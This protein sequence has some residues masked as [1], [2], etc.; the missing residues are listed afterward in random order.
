MNGSFRESETSVNCRPQWTSP[1]REMDCRAL[2]QW[3]L[4]FHTILCAFLF[5]FCLG[6]VSTT[7]HPEDLLR[8]FCLLQLALL[9]WMLLSWRVSAGSLFDP[10]TLF[11]FAAA[12]FHIG[13]VVLECFHLNQ[14]AMLNNEFP[15]EILLRTVALVL[16]S[17]ALL[18]LGALLGRL[19][20]PR[21]T[22]VRVDSPLDCAIVR[23]IGWGL[24]A[25]SVVPAA[26][27]L[28]E[29][30]VNTL[31][32]GYFFALFSRQ[33]GTGFA[34]IESFLAA[35]LVP[36][37]FFLLADGVRN[38][39]SRILSLLI[40]VL[41]G[42]VFLVIGG[43]TVAAVSGATYAWMWDRLIGRLP[44]VLILSTILIGLFVI[45]PLVAVIRDS[46]GD[47]L[48]LDFLSQTWS[49]LDHPASA[50]LKETGGS[51]STVAYTVELVPSARDFDKGMS[52]AMAFLAVIPN[53]FWDI[54]P[55]VAYGTPGNWMM[56]IVAPDFAAAGGSLGYSFVAEAYYNFGWF[57]PLFI[58]GLG[59]A[60]G[61]L[62]RA[63]ANRPERLMYACAANILMPLLWYTRN[64]SSGAVRDI[65]WLGITPLLLSKV[66]KRMLHKSASPSFVH[67]APETH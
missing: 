8:T 12:M 33:G 42:G 34:G 29:T 15:P 27:Y 4:C 37:A 30:V 22:S 64:E 21:P 54:H 5:V 59:F 41:Y 44:R 23:Y 66:L 65:L 25:L 17:F 57:G 50:S 14:G 55:S 60:L 51:L 67:H 58:A 3:I 6:S 31:A 45:F 7:S 52:Y 32:G 47:R 10:Y 28:R 13:Q 39:S 61:R 53:L 11:V 16:L 49:S 63:T 18:H 62:V 1:F 9:A 19:G 24:F 56:S 36:S 35:F 40:V 2:S 43:R 46:H 26:L 38:R 20:T 48:S